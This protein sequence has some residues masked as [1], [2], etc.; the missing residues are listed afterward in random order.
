MVHKVKRNKK[1]LDEKE[2]PFY[3]MFPVTKR[4]ADGTLGETYPVGS[5]IMLSEG[6]AKPLLAQG[7]LAI[8]EDEDEVVQEGDGATPAGDN[9]GSDN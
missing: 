6:R 3:V 9:D 2:S 4:A 8:F 1:E 7:Y 5:T